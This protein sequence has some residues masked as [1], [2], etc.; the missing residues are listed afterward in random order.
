M[1]AFQTVLYLFG[2]TRGLA[3]KLQGSSMDVINAFSHID[4][5]RD[6]M[7]NARDDFDAKVY[8][9]I[10]KMAE[11][12]GCTLSI[13]RRCGRQIH[14]N[15]VTAA[16]PMDYFRRA[17]YLPF[18]DHLNEQLHQR[19]SG[20]TRQALEPLKLIPANLHQGG[21]IQ[22]DSLDCPNPSSLQ[23][24]ITLWKKLW[25]NEAELPSTITATLQHQL[26]CPRMYPNVTTILKLLLLAPVTAAS[27]ERSNSALKFIKSDLRSTMT[28]TRFNALI[29]MFVHKDITINIDK[30]I[31]S[32]AQAQPRKLLF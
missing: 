15:N 7:A 1:A 19:F 5:I 2:F 13:P 28:S 24:E 8:P 29:L 12:A 26:S 9:A 17:I 16:S 27:V 3:I 10:E 23:Q 11:T 4:H 20:V 21:P 31:D 14:R 25:D 22:L 18:I 32:F 30:I 6:V